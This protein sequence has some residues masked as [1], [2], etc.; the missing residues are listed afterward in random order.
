MVTATFRLCPKNEHQQSVNNFWPCILENAWGARRHYPI[1]TLSAAFLGKNS[2][3]TS[4][5]CPKNE[6]QWSVNDFWPCIMENPR[7]VRR[8]QAIITLLAAL[9]GKNG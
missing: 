5:L 4:L 6:R 8:H 7:A 1:I 9:P 3:K 2:G